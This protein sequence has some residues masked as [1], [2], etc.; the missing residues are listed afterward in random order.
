MGWFKKR[1]TYKLI[2]TPKAD[3]TPAQVFESI[4]PIQKIMWAV[5][6]DGIT[7]EVVDY[8]LKSLPNCVVTFTE[9]K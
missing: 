3:I 1:K 7:D 5:E 4:I 2:I 6:F 8:A 9:D